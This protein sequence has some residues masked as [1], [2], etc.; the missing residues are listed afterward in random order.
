MPQRIF[1]T[2][3]IILIAIAA[4]ILVYILYPLPPAEAPGETTFVKVFFSN[5]FEDPEGLYCDKVYFAERKAPKTQ[6]SL[7]LARFAVEELL[8]GP[9]D[10]EKEG[11]FFTNINPDVKINDLIVQEGEAA[12]DFNKTLE[13]NVGGSCRTAAIRAQIIETLKQ[14]PEIKEVIISVEGRTEGILQP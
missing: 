12:V 9:T 14:F 13:E 10:I 8:K 4:G 7:Q 1:Y 5:K 11:G 6:N 3:I 2:I